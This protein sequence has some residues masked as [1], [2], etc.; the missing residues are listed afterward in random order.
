M[1]RYSDN[2]QDQSQLPQAIGSAQEVIL[3]ASNAIVAQKPQIDQ[4]TKEREDMIDF[5]S[6]TTKGSD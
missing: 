4:L 3:V 2:L 5:R 6:T 1:T